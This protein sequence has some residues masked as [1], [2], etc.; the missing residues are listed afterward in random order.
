VAFAHD[1]GLVHRDLKPDNVMVGSFGEVLVLDWGVAKVLAPDDAVE[2]AAGGP[3]PSSAPGHT[4][5]GTVLGTPGFMPPEQASG[6]GRRVDQRSDVYALGALLFQMLSGRALAPGGDPA[7]AARRLPGVH[8]RLRAICAKALSPL[9][10]HRYADAGA[11]AGDVARFRAGDAVSAYPET[12]LDRI[13]R[14]AG[15]YRTAILLVLA[16]LVIR[17]IVALA[18][19]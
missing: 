11:L 6:D 1:R 16:Y 12:V 7:A 14:V 13:E 15:T 17:A 9:P 10:E 5:P 2:P 4:D 8:R 3:A 19:G 18:S